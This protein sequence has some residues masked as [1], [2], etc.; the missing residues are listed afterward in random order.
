MTTMCPC[1]ITVRFPEVETLIGEGVYINR[2]IPIA[3][4]N[5]LFNFFTR[6][7]DWESVFDQYNESTKRVLV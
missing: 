3:E 7:P 5:K 6:K 4:L 2:R 1:I